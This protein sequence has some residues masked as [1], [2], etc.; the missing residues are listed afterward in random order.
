MAQ[1]DA[2]DG[3]GI[4]KNAWPRFYRG[5]HTI[6]VFGRHSQSS[7]RPEHHYRTNARHD[8]TFICVYLRH[9]RL[10]ICVICVIGGFVIGVICG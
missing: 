8:P 7:L 9:L 10:V 2:E 5:A 4:L 6:C 1:I 3:F